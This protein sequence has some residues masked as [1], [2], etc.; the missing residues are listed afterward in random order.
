MIELWG[1]PGRSTGAGY[2]SPLY[3]ATGIQQYRMSLQEAPLYVGASPA[4]FTTNTQDIDW[5]AQQIAHEIL[6]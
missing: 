3:S 6:S 5:Y 1:A 4:A 2:G